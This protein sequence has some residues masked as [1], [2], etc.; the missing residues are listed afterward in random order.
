MID[1]AERGG[2]GKCSGCML[3]CDVWG[4]PG[5]R[6]VGAECPTLW[7]GGSKISLFRAVRGVVVGGCGW[8]SDVETGTSVLG[9]AWTVVL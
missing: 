1:D 8:A 5:V 2:G 6:R 4:V 7:T 3:V 9:D